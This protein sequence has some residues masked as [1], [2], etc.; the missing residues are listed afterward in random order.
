MEIYSCMCIYMF[1]IYIYKYIYVYVY[2][3]ILIF[4]P[5]QNFVL[6]VKIKANKTSFPCDNLNLHC[7]SGAQRVSLF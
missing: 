5:L 2:I 7:L 1:Y 4:L 6:F 3:Y